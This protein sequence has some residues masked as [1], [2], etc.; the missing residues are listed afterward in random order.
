MKLVLDTSAILSG[1][2]F[3]GDVYVP[4][5]VVRESGAQGLDPRTESFLEAK[6]R[7]LEPRGEDL[8]DVRKASRETGDDAYLS[9]TDVDVLALALQ[10]EATVVTDDYS[11]QNVASRL[12]LKYRTAILPGIRENVG[13]S[14]RCTGC[15]RYWRGAKD[16]CPVCGSTVRRYRLR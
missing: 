8:E 13:W 1:M 9:P 14:F 2:D 4:S 10:L 15:G 3:A 12:G 11:I 6:T 5:S 7:V 16:H